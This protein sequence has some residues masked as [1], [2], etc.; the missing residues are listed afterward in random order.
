M[1]ESL[2]K[3]FPTIAQSERNAL[4][5]QV[6][7]KEKAI[8]VLSGSFTRLEREISHLRDQLDTQARSQLLVDESTLNLH[9]LRV[10]FAEIKAE[11][12]R[13]LERSSELEQ[14]QH[15]A[16]TKLGE[17]TTLRQTAD[18]ECERLK[19]AA[20]ELREKVACPRRR[21]PSRLT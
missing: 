20:T 2:L 15:G 17:E 13:S 9:N 1:S 10:E 18:E 21:K 4:L 19:L 6:E 5:S 12:A 7:A 11:L 3:S 14:K 8:T 16:A